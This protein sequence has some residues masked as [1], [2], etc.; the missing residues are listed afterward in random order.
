MDAYICLQLI[1]SDM[2][3]ENESDKVNEGLFILYTKI[4]VMLHNIHLE[5]MFAK[6]KKLDLSAVEL[7]LIN[8]VI[9]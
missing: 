4:F 7:K 6:K 5:E 3:K 8:C 9:P 1:E 2:G